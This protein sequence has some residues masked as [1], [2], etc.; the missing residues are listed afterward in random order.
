MLVGG[1]NTWYKHLHTSGTYMSICHHPRPSCLWSFSLQD[2]DN[3]LPLFIALIYYHFELLL[4][5]EKIKLCPLGGLLFAIVFP[6][7]L[8]Q[9][10]FVVWSLSLPNSTSFSF[11]LSWDSP[12]PPQQTSSSTN[13]VSAS[14][15]QRSGWCV[16]PLEEWCLEEGRV[17]C[18]WRMRLYVESKQ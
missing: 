13:S 18:M 2:P 1:T 6:G 3:H 11:Y 8:C 4:L 5:H 15:F 14:V 16:L 10:C 7:H 12:S 9:I 17:V